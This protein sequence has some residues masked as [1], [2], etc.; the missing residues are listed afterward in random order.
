[1]ALVALAF[2]N[3]RATR[4]FKFVLTALAIVVITSISYSFESY[5]GWPAEANF[6]KGRLKGV[7]IINP[8]I[9]TNG[10]IYLWLYPDRKGQV[11][12]WLSNFVYSDSDLA[13]LN[14]ALPYSKEAAKKFAA[15]KKQV[16]S[17]DVV[18]IEKNGQ[19]DDI[20]GAGGKGGKGKGGK[21]KPGLEGDKDTS[22][23]AQG[24]V[25]DD[26][27]GGYQFKVTKPEDV[28]KKGP[29]E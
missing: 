12:P 1:V 20:G 4:P 29:G 23:G 19:G 14:Y 15:A 6:I 26:G 11:V 13:P 5:K 8:G 17:G 24:D 7:E 18:D 28:L 3:H 27:S 2:I 21:G 22:S 10:H 16:E 9:N 25:P